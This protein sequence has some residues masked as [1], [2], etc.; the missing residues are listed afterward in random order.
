MAENNSGNTIQLILAIVGL[1]A[2]FAWLMSDS[3]GYAASGPDL[4]RRLGIIAGVVIVLLTIGTI[5]K[6]K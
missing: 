6:K 1:V 3:D 4:V 2:I 5:T